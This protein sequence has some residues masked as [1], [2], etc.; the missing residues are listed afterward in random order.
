MLLYLLGLGSGVFA[1]LSAIASL[2]DASKGQR[3]VWPWVYFVIMLGF[4]LAAKWAR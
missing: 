2:A 3:T 4:A 1:S